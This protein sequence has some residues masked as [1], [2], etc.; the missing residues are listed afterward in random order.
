MFMRHQVAVLL[1]P[2]M[3]CLPLCLTVAHASDEWQYVVRPGDTLSHIAGRH[4]DNTASWRALQRI[5]KVIDP[6]R[7]KPGSTLRIPYA[8]SGGSVLFADA[9]WVRGEVQHSAGGTTT[10][11]TTGTQ[12][13]IGEMIATGA[14]S[15]ATLRFAD[16]SRL[17]IAPNSR[18]LLTHMLR[19]RQSGQVATA[20]TLEAGSVES[21]V[22]RGEK[23]DARYEVKTPTLNLAVRGT[24]FRVEVDNNTGTTR[25]EVVEGEVLASAQ[26]KEVALTA[27][28]GTHAA[29]GAPPAPARNLLPAPILVAAAMQLETLPIRF[30]WREA[31][32]AKKYRIELLDRDG[33]SQVDELVSLESRARWANLPDGEYQLRVRGIDASGLEGR[34]AVHAFALNGQ[35]APPVLRHPLGGTALDGEKVAFRWAR[36]LGIQYFRLQ[37]S[38]TADFARIVAQVKQLPGSVGG[39]NLAL[40]PGRYFWRV[41]ASHKELGWGPDSA[42]AS[43]ELQAGTGVALATEQTVQLAW[44]A[45]GAGQKT[46]L[47]VASDVQFA[48]LLLDV[49]QAE[50]RVDFVP[51][52]KGSFFLRLRRIE[53]DGLATAFEATQQLLSESR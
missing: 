35:P 31:A 25:S 6:D 41:A 32:E 3:L 7:L 23:V 16:Q 40:P 36:P 21:L 5:N 9:A 27:G 18:V 14:H 19:D 38:D 44:K 39:L 52:G 4:L 8:L 17:M 10:P 11:L 15:S 53:P 13:R 46:Q 51:P 24:R 37:V 34:A 49:T 2:L 47:Q 43:F 28:Q 50:T 45:G 33:A 48:Q 29:K 20:L 1:L 22:Q 42:V 30:D 12:L 26:G